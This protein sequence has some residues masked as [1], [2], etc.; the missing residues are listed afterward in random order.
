[1]FFLYGVYFEFVGVYAVKRHCVDNGMKFG[2]DLKENAVN[3]NETE[4]GNE[5]WGAIGA[6]I[7]KNSRF[8]FLYLVHLLFFECL[9]FETANLSFHKIAIGLP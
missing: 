9:L 2:V 8:F 3:I 7:A 1:M 4:S 6:S 5:K